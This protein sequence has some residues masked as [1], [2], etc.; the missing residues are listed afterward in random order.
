MICPSHRPNQLSRK[1]HT[2]VYIAAIGGSGRNELDPVGRED[3]CR[4]L[5]GG[6]SACVDRDPAIAHLWA[7]DDGVAM[8]DPE[9]VGSRGFPEFGMAPDERVWRVVFQGCVRVCAGMYDGHVAG[10]RDAV[11]SGKPRH[12]VFAHRLVQR[13]PCAGQGLCAGRV[14]HACHAE[15]GQRLQTAI[16]QP[17]APVGFGRPQEV[18]HE[19]F[20]IAHEGGH[21]VGLHDI[22]QYLPALFATVHKIADADD[23][24]ILRQRIDQRAQQIE[25]AVDVADHAEGRVGAHRVDVDRRRRRFAFVEE[26][27][28]DHAAFLFGP[29]CRAAFSGR[30]EGEYGGAILKA[31]G[32]FG[33]QA[34]VGV[35]L[36]C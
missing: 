30:C 19:L 10:P 7:V 26:F 32:F 31:K 23:A 15:A 28:K 4:Q 5:P 16:A 14:G 21:A 2:V 9:A 1:Q 24:E 11:Q 8:H 34:V 17:S 18:E 33:R 12:H 27:G 36:S 25:A 29:V 22:V 20:V 6:I 13:V 35:Q 3:R